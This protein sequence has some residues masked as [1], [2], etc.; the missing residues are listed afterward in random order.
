MGFL[1]SRAYN[2]GAS[3]S[4]VI[5][6]TESNE[7]FVGN[8][9][10]HHFNIILSGSCTAVTCVLMYGLMAMH[11]LRFSNPN[12]Q[13]KIM[14]IAHML[15]A[16]SILSFIAIVWPGTYVYM[17]GWVEVFQ[18][19]A[20]YA[21]LMLCVDFLAPRDQDKI[22]FF[23]SLKVPKSFKK[24]KY[25][26]GLSWFK[27]TYYSVVQ[28]PLVVFICAIAACVTQSLNV[29]CLDSN[30]PKYGHIWIEVFQNLSVSFAINAIFRFY[31]NTKAYCKEAKPL[32]KLLA[33]KLMVGLIFIEQIAFMVL[34]ATKVLYPTKT[35]SYADIKIGLPNLIICLQMVPFSIL[36]HFAYD[37][38]PYKI[39]EHPDLK[40]ER[41][42]SNEGFPVE[43]ARKRYQHGSYQGGPFGNQCLDHVL[44][45]IRI[46]Q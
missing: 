33:F 16:Y 15:P 36:M 3:C 27:L 8:L 34:E 38:K 18:A 7:P 28:Y 13:S 29:Y 40:L 21:Y 44:Q 6:K 14:R 20:L 30:S 31:T 1:S 41:P 42:D 45:S 9:S 17:T 43:Q 35:I 39:H 2:S 24:G 11:A 25:R 23:T 4:Q 22:D 26:E 32:L 19:I 10:F 12:E 46:Y 37:T 5:L